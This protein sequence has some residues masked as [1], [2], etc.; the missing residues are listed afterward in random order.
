RKAVKAFRRTVS[1]FKEQLAVLI[2]TIGGGPPR[3][4]DL[5]STRYCNTVNGGQRNIFIEDG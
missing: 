5:I 2:Y 3:V 1:G 4:L